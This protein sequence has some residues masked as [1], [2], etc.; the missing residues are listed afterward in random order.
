MQRDKNQYKKNH[1][2]LKYAAVKIVEERKEARKAK[3]ELFNFVLANI[4][5]KV[6]ALKG[7]V[8]LCQLSGFSS[9][10]H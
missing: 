2:L 4:A 8:E 5:E 6:P 7:M 10:Y 3:I 1:E 9:M